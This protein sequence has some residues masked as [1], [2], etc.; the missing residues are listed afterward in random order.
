MTAPEIYR[1]WTREQRLFWF[2]RAGSIA[3]G[4]AVR[5]YRQ[6]QQHAY[7]PPYRGDL[8]DYKGTVRPVRCWHCDGSADLGHGVDCAHCEGV[9]MVTIP[10]PRPAYVPKDPATKVPCKPCGAQGCDADGV[11]CQQCDGEG[12][13]LL[14]QLILWEQLERNRA[15]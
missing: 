2:R 7:L 1:N 9:G 12:H 4:D 3:P 10:W 5:A 8:P 11:I 6:A 14:G 15:A 13:V